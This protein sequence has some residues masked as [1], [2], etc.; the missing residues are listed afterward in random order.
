MSQFNIAD[1]KARFSELVRKALAGEE[2]IIAKGNEPLLRLVPIRA[3]KGKRRPGSA[4]DKLVRLA[5]DFD[6][7]PEEFADYA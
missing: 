5:P 7:I 6:Q 3:G 4:K 1:A 2:V